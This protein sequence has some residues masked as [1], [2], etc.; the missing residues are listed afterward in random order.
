MLFLL[1]FTLMLSAATWYLNQRIEPFLHAAIKKAVSQTT[2]SLYTLDFSKVRINFF[3]GTARMKDVRLTPDT[4]VYQRQVK[5]ESAPNNLYY[6]RLNQLI[7]KGINVWTVYFHRDLRIKSLLFDHPDIQMENRQW[8]FNEDKPPRPQ[9]PPYEFISNLLQS[10]HVETIEFRN[11]RFKY[12]SHRGSRSEIDSVANLHVTLNDWL[13][14]SL[15]ATDA[16]RIYLLK[17][18]QVYLN[19]YRYATP[20]SMYFL[21][22]DQLAFNSVGGMLEV[23]QFR[24]EP[25]YSEL[26]F[27]EVNGYARDRYSIQL[28]NVHLQGL[29]LPAYI[30]KQEV[31]GNKL[32]VEDGTVAVFNDNSYPKR[33][34][35]KTGRYPHQLLQQLPL[36]VNL[37]DIELKNIDVSYS[38]HDR[39]SK[40]TGKITFEQTTGSIRHVTNIPRVKAVSP[41]MTAR[42]K[43]Q[44]MGQGPLEVIFRFH[45]DAPKGDFSYQGKLGEMDGRA[46][47]RITKP[48]GMIQINKGQIRELDFDVTADEDRA[49]GKLSFR[50]NDLSVGL[51]K[52]EE[53]KDR[54]VKQGL[55]SMLANALIID[56]DNPNAEGRFTAATVNY[57]RQETASFFNFI[58]RTLF[59]GVK[60]SV[61]VS[62]AKEA[63]V[64]A[65]IARFERMKQDREERRNRR[66]LR[67]EQKEEK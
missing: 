16:S 12:I 55:I 8:A 20:D 48:L 45:L 6:I 44:V 31:L 38:E 51:L 26:V 53:G 43:S 23:K 2:D 32:Q 1:G 27:P 17:Q 15:S 37:G 3:T 35:V 13:I 47:N 19:D 41:E 59:Q 11:S 61:G 62:P 63:E 52:K 40:Q 10:L 58:W 56:G 22:A 36:K 66:A 34:T 60:Y 54:L 4:L 18:V 50:Y 42:L 25:R 29:D 46:F 14:D 65:Q 67:K 64:R 39:D 21:K 5:I 49:K 57:K 7:L 9:R 24:L 33:E 28:N 30:K